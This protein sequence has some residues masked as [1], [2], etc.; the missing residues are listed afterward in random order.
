MQL[1]MPAPL[2]Q[3]NVSQKPVR[4]G[5][6]L[7]AFASGG[8]GRPPTR[9]ELLAAP[10]RWPRPSRLEARWT[11]R[12]ARVADGLQALG[13]RS[14]GRAARAP[15]AGQ[16]RGAHVRGLQ[17][18][19]EATV[20]VQV[21]TIGARPVRRRGMRP[22]VEATVFDET[23]SMRATF[24]NQP[25][26]AQRYKPGTRLVLHGKTTARGTFNVSHHAVG[27]DLGADPGAGEIGATGEIVAHYPATEGVSSTQILTL[28]HGARAA[29]ARRAGGAERGGAGQPS[30]CPTEQARWR[31]CTSR[32]HR[33]ARGRPRTARVRGAAADAARVPAPPRHAPG[34]HGRAAAG[35]RRRR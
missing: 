11:W 19:E 34:A 25:W 30:G 15:A 29:L 23:G 18:G 8:G 33:G 17:A 1:R 12:P 16:P 9:Q 20:A 22:L 10:V 3:A 5:S 35:P 13:L 2:A 14:V 24:F 27:A 28:V 21:R 26:L 31:R 7:W 32:A 4:D 6:A